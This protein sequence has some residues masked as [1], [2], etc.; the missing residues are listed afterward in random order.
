MRVNMGDESVHV[1]VHLV[2]SIPPG[3]SGAQTVTIRNYLAIAA[4]VQVSSKSDTA[5]LTY[6]SG[7]QEWTEVVQVQP[8]R[9][10]VAGVKKKPNNLKHANPGTCTGAGSHEVELAASYRAPAAGP[11]EDL[12]PSSLT[13]TC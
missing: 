13:V 5:D 8:N 10:G 4:S 3:Q 11:Q 12:D 7:Q 6:Q 1:E 2:D 9:R